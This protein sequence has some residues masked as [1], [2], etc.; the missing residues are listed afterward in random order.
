MA[1]LVAAEDLT[2]EFGQ[3]QYDVYDE[4]FK[5]FQEM[6]G[7]KIAKDVREY[8]MNNREAPPLVRQ[9]L[10]DR[11]IIRPYWDVTDAYIRANPRV[12]AAYKA[13]ERARTTGDI[14]AQQILKDHPLLKRMDRYLSGHKRLLRERNPRLDATLIFWG[15][16]PTRP[17]T[18]LANTIYERM[19]ADSY[20]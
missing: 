2:D 17:L 3:F 6:F 12:R 18:P 13:R 11:E 1:N 15:V 5:L 10:S 20:K 14:Q 4:K 8:S 16:G 7:V 19:I 9:W